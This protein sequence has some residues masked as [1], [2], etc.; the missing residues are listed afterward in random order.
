MFVKFSQIDVDL[1]Y[2]S[3]GIENV[4]KGKGGIL[5]RRVFVRQMSIY[6]D[7]NIY[8]FARKFRNLDIDDFPIR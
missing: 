2:N 3:W 8:N 1:T 6:L 7:F 4:S 5:I